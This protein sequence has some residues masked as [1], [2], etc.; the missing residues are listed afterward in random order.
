MTINGHSS[1]H[2]DGHERIDSISLGAAGRLAR[3]SG[4]RRRWL[5]YQA[6]LLSFR[7][8]VLCKRM[9]ALLALYGIM[10]GV[11]GASPR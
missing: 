10:R 11:M 3:A 6:A 4:S 7:P 1:V 2:E 9:R 5:E 8:L